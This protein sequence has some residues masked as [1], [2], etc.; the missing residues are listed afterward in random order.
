MQR[1]KL[2]LA[3]LLC[4]SWV[5]SASAQTELESDSGVAALQDFSGGVSLGGG[6][7]FNIQHL[8][9]GGVGYTN[10]YT[11][12]G[13]FVP[14]WMDED[15]LVAPTGRIFF[16]NN[17]NVGGSIGG[18]FRRYS[19]NTDRISGF[20][21]YG[22]FEQSFEGF[23]YNQLGFGFESLGELFDMRSNFYLP[24][25]NDGNFVQAVSLGNTP[26]F[27]GNGIN[28][29]GVGQFQE[30]IR[31][32]D[33]EVG[34][35]VTPGT[36]WL[37]AYAGI[38]GYTATGSDPVGV[39]GRLEAT[40]SDDLT[41]G[42][43]VTEDQRFGTNV[44]AMV[45][46]RFSGFKPTRYF[47]QWTTRER[48]LSSVQRNGRIS[49]AS[50]NR[51]VPI[52]AVNPGTGNPYFVVWVDNSNPLPG[53]G[54]F[55]NPYQDFQPS[56]PY[57]EADLILVRRGNSNV[58]PLNGPVQLFDNQ[59]LLGEGRE[60][61]FA[62]NAQFEQLVLS[63][64]FQMPGFVNNGLYP[65]ITAPGDIITIANNNE[66]SAF[67][68]INAGGSAITNDP[69]VG[70]HNFNINCVD[71]V[72]NQRGIFLQNTSGIGV[73]SG[74]NALD[75]VLGGIQIVN[76]APLDLIIQDVTSNSS[77]PGTQAVG[78]ELSASNS[79]L[80][81]TM[82]NVSTIGNAA[83][84]RI[85]ALNS[86][87]V[88]IFNTVNASQNA[89]PGLQAFI[90]GG[91]LA[92]AAN[93]LN[94]SGNVQDNINLQF[95][96]GARMDLIF[97]NVDASASVAGNGIVIA[98]N[99]GTG[100]A[101]LDVVSAAGNAGNG[102]V[103][104]GDNGANIEAALTGNTFLNN[105]LQSAFQVG[106]NNLSIV[107]L[108]AENVN[109]TG[110]GADG[111]F[112]SATGNSVMNLNFDGV[113]LDNSGLTTGGRGILGVNVDS[114]V[115][116]NFNNVTANNNGG[117]GL[118]LVSVNG[119]NEIRIN[120]GSYS[121]NGQFTA[122]SAGINVF[123]TNASNVLL[124]V[125]SAPLNNDFSVPATQADGLRIS[126][127]FASLVTAN[128]DA[129]DM[130]SNL[131]NA[132]DA[133][134]ATNGSAV[135]NM[136]NSDG[137]FS[138][139]SGVR[140]DAQTG[141]QLR[142]DVDNSAINFSGANGIDAFIRSDADV[143]VNVFNGSLVILSGQNGLKVDISDAGST[144]VG[145]FVDSNLSESGFQGLGVGTQDAMHIRAFDQAQVDL[146]L[147]NTPTTNFG[148]NFQQRGLFATLQT[149]SVLNFNNT[150]GDMSLNTMN[151]IALA[152]ANP[153]S[154][155]NLNIQ[156]T[157][158]NNSGETGFL[159][160]A[161]D[162]GTINANINNSSLD[163][164]GA[165]GVQG[166]GIFGVATTGGIVNLSLTNTPVT[167]ALDDA[168]FVVATDLGTTVNALFD[169]SPLDNAGQSALD[170][171]FLNGAAGI[172]TLIN[173]ST[174]TNAGLDAVRM[175]ADGVA[176][177][178][179]T[180]L[181]L[182]AFD[183]N[184]SD[185]GQ[186]VPSNGIN[187]TV[188]LNANAALN[189][190]NTPIT[191]TTGTSPQLRGLLF[192]V[193][194][195]GNLDA[196]F[197]N[198]DLS[199]HDL[200]GIN[201]LVDGFNLTDS[202]AFIRLDNTPVDGNVLNGAL[203]NVTNRGDLIVLA[204]NGTSFEN[205]GATGIQTFVD[206]ALSTATF[207]LDNV[208]VDGN[209]ALVGGDGMSVIANNAASFS[210]LAETSSF[211]NNANR[212]IN[213]LT[214]TA[215]GGFA[216]FNTPTVNGNQEEGLY[217]E[218]NTGSTLRTVVVGGSLSD[219]GLAGTFNN[220]TVIATQS[221][222]V[223]SYFETVTADNSTLN[224]FGF[225][226]SLGSILLGQMRNGVTANDNVNGSGVQFIARDAFTQGVLY[227]EGDNAFDNNGTAVVGTNVNPQA[228]AGVFFDA[229][230]VDIAGI[231][232]AGGAA[233]NG[234]AANLFADVDG[235]GDR[236]DD[237]VYVR[238]RNTGLAAAE[239][240]GSGLNPISNNQ[241]D[242]IDLEMTNVTTIGPIVQPSF[243]T[244]PSVVIGAGNNGIAVD[245]LVVDGNA[246]N[247]IS[248][249]VANTNMNGNISVTNT[250]S[251]NNGGEGVLIDL[252]NVTGMPSVTIA[253]SG[254]NGNGLN[255]VNLDLLN[256]S[257]NEL[258][259]RDNTGT[260]LP[261]LGFNVE[262]SGVHWEAENRLFRF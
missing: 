214:T 162:S 198:S 15:T 44:N 141:G 164:S 199:N 52:A 148:L 91:S 206:G 79:P 22:D 59:R 39:R 210:I 68:L 129:V 235:D 17:Q 65:T 186:V 29:I 127:N 74:S 23:N 61:S 231:R 154:V 246:G 242:G 40:V 251:T 124:N 168:V 150:N 258:I 21:I 169:A 228:G 224:G 47:P 49:M 71:M 132:I 260:P 66:V 25:T 193:L 88:A 136:V 163:S 89:G 179:N 252:T 83:G 2:S 99:G 36:P 84:T 77:V 177:G 35:P 80:T 230:G 222:I 108:T 85:N 82:N 135:I 195:G 14:Y 34:T 5:C 41:I 205:N 232:F 24:Q 256:A 32:G 234:N 229:N 239:F 114:T 101:F 11:N 94:A 4:V 208:A 215:A 220:V 128:L 161:S 261:P 9:G 191:N 72:N 236:D 213:L 155:A 190:I 145:N 18:V 138:G 87:V 26:V 170:L 174:G 203:F 130:T 90:D 197:I 188:S 209:G 244:P 125:A 211:S 158:M 118:F 225:D 253:G 60:H 93:S 240:V 250:D 156:G 223:E 105:N 221:S 81:V 100:T 187:I 144:F 192:N 182:N 55:E 112:F 12:I 58:V 184:F 241:G 107:S 69:L 48:M 183:S 152:V 27:A 196:N 171:T 200:E 143:A 245:N 70:S 73:V 103:F 166:S 113:Q 194:S 106:A 13:A 180:S 78:I 216:R 120:G 56:Q 111:L 50:F 92:M 212:G 133:T 254:I 109:A 149:G 104:L 140:I 121:N 262:I 97:S 95:T 255:G 165:G 42:V 75:N 16:T 173:G 181:T 86:D 57:P 117:D 175:L 10:G 248:I 131:D 62:A 126:S 115:F 134:V 137:S 201:G 43:N 38:Y 3:C 147:V 1:V 249:V 46:F 226:V 257:I 160:F 142:L 6:A 64:V 247:G 7:Y 204:S 217:V 159:W 51:N 102:F 233:N 67:N 96:N 30:A 8:S 237:G 139:F 19:P 33:V 153:G 122:N 76:N 176:G 189:I 37:R 45:D 178:V 116:A 218:A 259:V 28:F 172:F 157:P 31:G 146:N 110:S 119:N 227:M 167:N 207:V 63:G 123:A 53:N 98:N 202:R 243:I 151:A 219:N 238:I 20:N 185:S 54:S